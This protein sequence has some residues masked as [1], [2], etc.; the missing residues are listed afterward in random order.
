MSDQEIIKEYHDYIIKLF[1]QTR[2]SFIIGAGCSKCAGLPLM[3]E[4]KEHV[5]EKIDPN[6][7]T[8]NL[9]NISYMLF[10]DI[11]HTY[12]DSPQASI[13]D[14]LSEIQDYYAIIHR[15]EERGIQ[16]SKLIINSKEYSKEHFAIL[17][18]KIKEVI[19][20][21]IGTINPDLKNHR[22]FCKALHYVLR[23]GREK[24]SQTINY[25]I[26]NYDTLFEDALALENVIFTDGFVG[27]VTAWWN[28]SFFDEKY[29]SYL[30]ILD[31]RI[32]KLHGSID[33]VKPE[34]SDF[35]MKVRNTIPL[36]DV[37]G[38]GESVMIYPSTAKY[39]ET[40]IDPFSLLTAKFRAC[41]QNTDNHILII[42]GYSFNDEHINIEIANGLR[43]S[44]GSLSVVVFLGEKDLPFSLHRIINDAEICSQILIIGENGIWKEG[45]KVFNPEN[46][47]DWYKFEYITSLIS[48]E[49]Q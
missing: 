16:N 31:A 25:F 15:Q 8:D 38:K 6:T 18:K 47:L 20:N 10:R 32:Y 37:I 34:K 36:E 26:L 23:K 4:M 30:N 39:K 28:P 27:G 17:M 35:P 9:T 41:V 3:D 43:K 13:E 29:H 14:Y 33:W 40:Q 7:V 22:K 11:I 24:S 21:R 5:I 46:S 49:I 2:L 48:G 12:K 19:K 45:S 44:N 42:I 1:S